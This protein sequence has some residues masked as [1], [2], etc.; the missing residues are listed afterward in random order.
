MLQETPEGLYCPAGGFHIDPWQPVARALITHAH[1]DHARP[2]HA[3]Y[4]CTDAS[5]PL[6]RR[7]FGV[8][9]RIETLPYGAAMTIGGVRVSFHP[10]GHVLGSAQIR[11]EGP[12]G[13]WVV[14]GD[15][16]RAADPTCEPFEPVR[17]D[18]FIT[19]STFGLPIYRWQPQAEVYGEINDWWRANAEEGR[20]SVLYCYSFGKAQR[21]LSG[22]DPSIGPIF[23]H[24]AVEPLNRAYR[25][26]GVDLPETLLVTEAAGGKAAFRDALI[27]APPSAGGSSWIRRFGDYSDAFA[28]GW[29][30]LRGARRRRAVDRGFIL[31][32]HA[33]WPGLMSAIAATQASRV[34]VTHGQ[35][36]VMVRWLE[37]NGL[38]AGAFNTEYGD[39]DKEDVKEDAKSA[40]GKASPE[41]AAHA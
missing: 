16:K 14:S 17:C 37:Q 25:A 21:I 40:D 31:S 41:P 20:A 3:A 23:C 10:A 38:E 34:I 30:Q 35:V 26:S 5:A 39:D 22:L 36:G 27:L 28:S 12:D 4:L 15:Y 24:G 11:I 13:V 32:D 19:E 9:T 18:T 1:G 29:M 2:G 33:D 8:D 6:L 7:R